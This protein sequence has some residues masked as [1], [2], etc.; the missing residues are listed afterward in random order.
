MFTCTDV[1]A[2]L[3]GDYTTWTAQWKKTVDTDWVLPSSLYFR[4]LQY[5]EAY[6]DKLLFVAAGGDALIVDYN[7]VL[8]STQ[9]ANQPYYFPNINFS[10]RK[11][12]VAFVA[13]VSS[14]SYLYIYK[15]GN[16]QQTIDLYALYGWNTYYAYAA[17][18]NNGE[19]VAV[20]NYG[21]KEVVLFKGT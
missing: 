13:Q 12:F 5:M 14:K 15:N 2:C 17:I 8:L 20:M 4:D 16:L 6:T 18:S 11:K 1:K 21:T 3:E 19:Y 10:V 9:L 7:G